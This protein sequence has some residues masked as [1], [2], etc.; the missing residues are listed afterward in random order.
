M[1]VSIRTKAGILI[2][3]KC[4]IIELISGPSCYLQ[5]KVILCERLVSIPCQACCCVRLSQGLSGF[6]LT[7]Y[8]GTGPHLCVFPGPLQS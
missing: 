1:F 6:S 4:V 3:K 8:S 7:D 2:S 5:K